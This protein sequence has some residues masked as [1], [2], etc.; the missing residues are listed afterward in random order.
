VILGGG[1]AGSV[2]SRLRTGLDTLVVRGR[3]G[4]F[5]LLPEFDVLAR[6]ERLPVTARAAWIR[7][8]LVA[9]PGARPWAVTVRGAD[10]RLCAAAILLDEGTSHA[11]LASGGQ[12][13][14]GGISAVDGEGIA[15]LGGRLA[16]EADVH[17]VT[18][19]L[20]G[21]PDDDRTRALADALG[22]DV[23]PEPPIPA[24]LLASG[25]AS[26]RDL[27]GYLAHGTARTLRKARNR[28]A[29]DGRRSAVEIT[30]RPAAVA[31]WLPSMERA[32]RGRDREHG[33]VCALDTSLGLTRWRERIRHLLDERCL[34]LATITVDGE[35]AAYVLGVRDGTRYGVLEGHFDTAW[36]RYSPGRLLEAEVLR[37]SLADPSIESVD[38]MTSVAPYS[39][40]AA[41]TAQAV[42]TLRRVPARL[43]GRPAG[44]SG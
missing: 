32:H 22:A 14:R 28:L 39:L 44:T 1:A 4:V 42:V 26:L 19:L 13:Y 17:A 34:E 2:P 15:L 10:G 24:L 36:S 6:R 27:A 12:G 41:N 5:A 33:V 29:A 25:D 11:V 38:W 31:A 9:D 18:L 20:A 43:T 40:L 35:F 8:L 3:A 30:R 16:E 21:L 23:A 7:A 37:R